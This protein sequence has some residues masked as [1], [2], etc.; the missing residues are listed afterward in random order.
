MPELD[1]LTPILERKRREVARRLRHAA[2]RAEAADA[3][4]DRAPAASAALRRGPGEPLRVIAEIKRCSPSAG[5][6]RARARGDVAFLARAYE[7]GGASAVSVLCDGPGFGGSPL[8]VRRAVAAVSLPILFKEFVLDEIQLRLARDVGAHMVLL[9]VRAMPFS[10]LVRL[11]D[12]TLAAGLSPVVEAANADELDAA[13]RT[14]ATIVGVNARDLRTFQVDGAMARQ[15]LD[16]VPRD[17]IAVHM[18]GVRDAAAFAEVSR[19]RA[20]AV[21]IGEGL[22]RAA[23]PAARLRELRGV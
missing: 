8:D 11:V 22:V 2:H 6:L 7:R 17:R 1:Y 21:L 20:D 14:Q 23:D 9:L 19:G 15:A 3:A 5:V 12:A 18:S 13:L 10:Q 16:R 4:L